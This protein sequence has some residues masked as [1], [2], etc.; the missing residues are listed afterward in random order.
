MSQTDAEWLQTSRGTRP[1]VAWSF[2]TDAPLACLGL[3][4]ET[5][6]VLAADESGGLYRLDRRGH[7]TNL[8]RGPT[9]IRGLGWSDAGNGGVALVGPRKLFWF[10]R[11]LKFEGS[12]DLPEDA[13]CVAVDAHGDYAAA[14]LADG[15]TL[16]FDGPRKPLHRFETPRPLVRVEFVVSTP[17]ILG[18]A[19]YGLLCRHEFNGEAEW[20]EKLWANV[21]DLAVSGSGRVILAAC[22]MHGIQRFDEAGQSVGSYQLEGTV[23]R[24]SQTYVPLRI[25][26][27]TLERHLYWLDSDGK[28]LWA[29]HG[30]DD[31]VRV[32]CAPLGEGIV[33]GF[34]SGRILGLTW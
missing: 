24:V 17:A 11:E 1:E 25:A 12:V 33:C 3:A 29:A 4:R 27:A 31:V 30:P 23:C 13:L 28:L 22:F 32:A 2:T 9:P 15:T 7:A 19:D 16:I 26:A 6:E 14:S 5:G 20:Q 8:T 10:T 34:Q 18:V 21:G